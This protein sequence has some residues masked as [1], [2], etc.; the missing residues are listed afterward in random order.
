MRGNDITLKRFVSDN[1]IKYIR[2]NA[3]VDDSHKS[4]IALI[5]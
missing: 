3:I 4:Q 5:A 1:V 2:N